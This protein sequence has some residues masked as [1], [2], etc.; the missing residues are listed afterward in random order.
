MTSS[1]GLYGFS[2]LT[3]RGIFPHGIQ[4]LALFSSVLL[5]VIAFA[6]KN[7]GPYFLSWTA[8]SII[9]LFLS[10]DEG[11]GLHELWTPLL[12]R[13]FDARGFLY[14]VWVVPYT[15]F[16]LIFALTYLSF[17]AHLPVKT[18]NL[19]LTAG[20]I[21][22]S[23]ALGM[24]LIEGNYA[25]SFGERNMVMAILTTIEEFLEMMGVVVFIYALMS[26]LSSETK[27]VGICI[28]T[29]DQLLNTDTG[30]M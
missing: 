15:A 5:A 8:L 22:V 4:R 25:N 1:L 14:F 24:E 7:G 6:K 23:G 29:E 9:F 11:A 28:K 13:S 19:F 20:A 12:L 17:L 26:Y 3:L 10:L 16:V 30:F 27:N 2:T 18:R 21:F